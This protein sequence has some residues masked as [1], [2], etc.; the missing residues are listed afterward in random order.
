MN[1]YTYRHRSPLV[2]SIDIALEAMTTLP[3]FQGEITRTF[4]VLAPTDG[5]GNQTCAAA[6][7]APHSIDDRRGGAR[8]DLLR[9]R[10]YFS[11]N[12]PRDRVRKKKSSEKKVFIRV[13]HNDLSFCE[14]LSGTRQPYHGK[15]SARSID[16]IEL[17]SP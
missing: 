16:G 1:M 7:A 8:V 12:S 13:D 10:S 17:Q 14:S 3:G 15:Q 4:I 5:I 2:D 6:A 9:S 11:R